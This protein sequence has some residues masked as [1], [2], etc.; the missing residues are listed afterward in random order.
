[1]NSLPSVTVLSYYSWKIFWF[2]FKVESTEVVGGNL[3]KKNLRREIPTGIHSPFEGIL[4]IGL[5]LSLSL[6]L[7]MSACLVLPCLYNKIIPAAD[8]SHGWKM[9]RDHKRA[10]VNSWNNKKVT[11]DVNSWL[12]GKTGWSKLPPEMC[13]NPSLLSLSLSLLLLIVNFVFIDE[14]LK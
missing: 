3:T 9:I 4:W 2:W 11:T 1:V 12:R 7:T 14:T 5:S 13:R 6:F 8:V 10:G